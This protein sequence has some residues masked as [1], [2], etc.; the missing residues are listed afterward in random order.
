[1]PVD[2]VEQTFGIA[3]GVKRTE[4]RRIQK[5]LTIDSIQRQEIPKRF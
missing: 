2:S 5:T 3:I 4:L 1:M